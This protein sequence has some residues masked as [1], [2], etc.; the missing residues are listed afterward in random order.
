VSEGGG[1]AGPL[2][3]EGMREKKK[4]AGVLIHL[5]DLLKKRGGKKNLE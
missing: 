1:K 5:V 3:E 2:R 4:V